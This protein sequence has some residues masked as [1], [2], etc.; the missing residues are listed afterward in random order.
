MEG[1]MTRLPGGVQDRLA[2]EA[3]ALR[4]AQERLLLLFT[5]WGYQ[6]IATPTFEFLEVFDDGRGFPR[7]N[8]YK[9]F[10]QRGRI[11][12]LRPDM[13]MPVA[14]LVATRLQDETM[15][16][17]LA[18]AAAV[19]RQNGEGRGESHEIHQAGGE[20]IGLAPPWGDAEILCLAREACQTLEME[21]YY[22]S[23]GHV[24]FF[25]GLAEEAAL[26]EKEMVVLKDSLSSRDFVS[27]AS[28]LETMKRSGRRIGP[29]SE[30]PFLRGRPEEVLK[31]A[32]DGC[33]NSKA[34]QALE[35][36]RGIW[37]A[38]RTFDPEVRLLLDLGLLRRPAYYTGA[39]FE[40]YAPSLGRPILGGGR[41][42]Q[43]LSSFGLERPA[44]GF[45]LILDDL[46][47]R[48][49][50]PADLA[51]NYL[52]V[53]A[54]AQSAQ[55][56]RR[57]RSLREKGYSVVVHIAT[58]R[59]VGNDAGFLSDELTSLIKARRPEKVLYLEE[60]GIRDLSGLWTKSR[61]PGKVGGERQ[62][63]AAADGIH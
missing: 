17:R 19:Y 52:L 26:T 10:D 21:D 36:V 2:G 6:E 22:I 53:A 57:A 62:A 5:T 58:S 42:D 34:R 11:L 33:G 63:P 50:Q 23:L 24:G 47:P 28:Q 46:L 15:P 16:L 35:E 44:V 48:L 27:Y 55:A 41:Y 7:E 39:V 32:G 25:A 56:Q 4:A 18:Y 12:A 30:L 3:R 13:T 60:S 37:E 14:R 51:L 59:F 49:V 61:S 54:S 20:L 1:Y 43:L 9:F 8:L 40:G 29:L 31:R 38:M 45:G